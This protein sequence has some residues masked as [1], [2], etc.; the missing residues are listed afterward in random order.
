MEQRTFQCYALAKEELRRFLENDSTSNNA[1]EAWRLLGH[2]CYQ[3]G[4]ALGEVHAFI[5]RA[6][7]SV[8]PFHDLSNT[9]NRL[10]LFLRDSGLDID[11]E[12]KRD[13]ATRILSVLD[14]RIEEAVG[15]DL[16]RMAWLAIHSGREVDA[17]RYIKAGLEIDSDNHH[18]HKLAQRFG[19]E[20]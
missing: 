4:D 1:A 8:L 20:Q 11:H 2:A 16:S 9:A 12:Q 7:V 6:Q 5:E 17:R 14:L 15:D 19:M 3:T 10:N 13:I 18:L